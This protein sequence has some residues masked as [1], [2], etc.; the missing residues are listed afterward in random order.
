MLETEKT[1]D[2]GNKPYPR[3]GFEHDGNHNY[4]YGWK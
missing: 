2:I 4:Y 1:N 3:C